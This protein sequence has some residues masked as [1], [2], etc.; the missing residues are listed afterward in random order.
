MT[1]LFSDGQDDRREDATKKRGHPDKSVNE[2]THGLGPFYRLK[3]TDLPAG[4]VTAPVV[5]PSSSAGGS[6]GNLSSRMKKQR[7]RNGLLRYY[8]VR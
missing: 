1:F 6:T 7:K 2:G 5:L 4:T 8:T 3:H